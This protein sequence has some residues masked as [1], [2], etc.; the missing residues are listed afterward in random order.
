[1]PT[2]GLSRMDLIRDNPTYGNSMYGT[3]WVG[4]EDD[5]RKYLSEHDPKLLKRNRC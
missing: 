1:M 3:T 5:V 4:T 2:R